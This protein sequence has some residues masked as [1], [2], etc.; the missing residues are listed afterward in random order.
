ME[1]RP[2]ADVQVLHRLANDEP[3]VFVL[4]NHEHWHDIVPEALARAQILAG[5]RFVSTTLRS[6]CRLA[7]QLDPDTRPASDRCRP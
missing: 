5:C 6:D 2:P 3:V 7:G 1:G 4:G